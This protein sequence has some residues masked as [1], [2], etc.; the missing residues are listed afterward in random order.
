MEK[1]EGEEFKRQLKIERTRKED[2]EERAR[3]KWLKDIQEKWADEEEERWD[4]MPLMERKMR[5]RQRMEEK[6]KTQAEETEKRW[7]RSGAKW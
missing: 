6:E 5:K 1:L 2:E 4:E 7:K 3:Y